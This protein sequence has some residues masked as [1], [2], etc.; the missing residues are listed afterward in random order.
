MQSA[1][2]VH[3]KKLSKRRSGAQPQQQNGNRKRDR[4][5]N[6]RYDQL[7]V[8]QTESPSKAENS[9]QENKRV[10]NQKRAGE[11]Q[12]RGCDQRKADRIHPSTKKAQLAG[13]GVPLEP[14]RGKGSLPPCRRER[15]RRDLGNNRLIRRLHLR[16]RRFFRRRRARRSRCGRVGQA[17]RGLR[18][19]R[20]G[21]SASM[22]RNQHVQPFRRRDRTI[23]FHIQ[24]PSGIMR[25]KARSRANFFTEP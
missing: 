17:R 13:R 18:R 2:T 8:V 1:G 21:T 20:S 5:R 4:I 10:G 15:N 14:S 7:P 11:L 23:F 22:G 16:K 25:R 3:G 19:R 6:R 12:Q 9:V 24:T